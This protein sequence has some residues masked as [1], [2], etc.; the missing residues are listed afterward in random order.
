MSSGISSGLKQDR[1]FAPE[2]S[3]NL[4]KPAIKASAVTLSNEIDAFKIET[5]MSVGSAAVFEGVPL[6]K[7]LWK[8]RKINGEMTPEM[9]KLSQSTKT[10]LKNLIHG[11]D[12]FLNRIGNFFNTI[13]LNK[14]TYN[15]IADITAAK[16]NLPDSA[17]TLAKKAKKAAE[18]PNFYRKWRLKSAE[19]SFLKT[20]S[21]SKKTV[22]SNTN[23]KFTINK[24]LKSPGTVFMA[25]FEGLVESVTE[26]YPAFKEL[27]A[28]KGLK[29]LG[30]STIKVAGDTIGFIIGDQTGLAIGSAIGSAI[31]P[32]IG[33]AIGALT[34]VVFGMFGSYAASKLTS[35][36]IGKSEME[37]AKEQQP[38]NLLTVSV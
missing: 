29:Q 17:E 35:K 33:T 5:A 20:L 2:F 24:I 7:Y 37:I 31:C 19:K 1:Q 36:I 16:A 22:N 32:G 18:S 27:G 4:I 11:D 9:K 21:E 30:K 15:R 10:A 8:N 12:K 23:S 28:E 38:Q 25:V 3:G 34:G 26:V 13:N 6:T 14:L